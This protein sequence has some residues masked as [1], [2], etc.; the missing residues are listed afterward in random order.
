M[1]YHGSL[2][3][4][5]RTLR[6]KVM[7][8]DTRVS[9]ISEESDWGDSTVWVCWV[10]NFELDAYN[11]TFPESLLLWSLGK[12]SETVISF[13]LDT[14]LKGSFCPCLLDVSV[15]PVNSPE[16]RKVHLSLL[17]LAPLLGKCLLKHT[18]LE[19]ALCVTKST[20]SLWFK[21]PGLQK[22]TLLMFPS[23]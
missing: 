4:P 18:V 1:I 15:L 23:T 8:A 20:K 12:S 9:V 19:E 22:L 21:G 11:N 14:A 5:R 10:I 13:F 17:L 6:M 16:R 3:S 7:S 2:F